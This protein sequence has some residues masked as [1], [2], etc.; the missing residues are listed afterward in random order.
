MHAREYK[1]DDSFLA[2]IDM[3][4]VIEG[5]K[6]YIAE[7]FCWSVAR[8]GAGVFTDLESAEEFLFQMYVGTTPELIPAE[9][10]RGWV[11]G[12]VTQH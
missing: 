7:Y 10:R 11:R 3:M 6:A 12:M 1:P 4:D 8:H 5:C 9:R 2:L